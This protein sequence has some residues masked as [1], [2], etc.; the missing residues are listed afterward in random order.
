MRDVRG[1]VPASPQDGALL[2]QGL[3]GRRAA[4][5]VTIYR[6][7]RWPRVRLAAKRRDGWRCVDCG[8]RLRLEVHH[9]E[10][11]GLR[12]DLAFDLDNLKTLCRAC[13][14]SVTKSEKWEALSQDKR[15]WREAVDG[16][17]RKTIP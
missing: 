2:L 11:V 1:G 3:R 10:R 9:V 5:A 13:H 14:I 12:P 6:D 7:P 4:E 16:L 8:S 15:A 17:Y